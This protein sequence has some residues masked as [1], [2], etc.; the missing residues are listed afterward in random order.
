MMKKFIKSLSLILCA[1]MCAACVFGCAPKTEPTPEPEPDGKQE[2]TETVMAKNG[3]TD[4]KIVVPATASEYIDFAAEELKLRFKEATKAELP[5]VKDSTVS[6]SES[7]KLISIGNTTV[8]TASGVTADFATYG[9]SG[10]KLVSKGD[11][12]ILTGA[13]DEGSLYAVY[14]LLTVLFDYEFY[15]IDAYKLN[16]LDT[17]Y[18]PVLDKS[19]IPDM[20]YRLYGDFL[21][22]RESGNDPH[23]A[24]RL[25]NEPYGQGV[26]V[27][28]HSFY[29]I[30]PKETYQA[31]HPDWFSDNVGGAGLGQLCLTAH[32]NPESR[33]KM[34]EE[35]AKSVES[36]IVA[37]PDSTNVTITQADENIWCNCDGCRSA[38]TKY[39][40]GTEYNGMF[41][42]VPFLND[43]AEVV[44]AWMEENF[45]GRHMTYTTLAYHQTINAPA[46]KNENGDYVPY[47][48]S[49]KLKDN[50]IISYAS[51][52]ANRNIPFRDNPTENDS[53]RA[54][55]AVCKGLQIYEYPQD[56]SHVCLPY[57]GLHVFA[58]NI[59]FAKELGLSNYFF[60]G[61]WG[62]QSSG[63]TPLKAYVT[64]KLMWDSS[65]DPMELAY[66]Y[67]DNCYG[68]AAPYIREYYDALRLRL[69]YM[70][71]TTNYGSMCL[72]NTLSIS[73]W[74]R[75]VIRSF[76]PYF[77]K[78]YAAIDNLQY[79][80]KE[81]YDIVFRKIMIEEM[82][83]RYVNCSLYRNSFSTE[84]KNRMI[85]EFE[86]YAG[87]YG[88]SR[89]SESKPMSDVISDWRR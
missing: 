53:I 84:E 72:G 26:A 31:E 22:D 83:L 44:D 41:T 10:A 5:I 28:G 13:T 37:K 30:M 36:F 51:I 63:F 68:D 65:L 34:V 15:D 20:Q 81:Q 11:C 56:A 86:Y 19:D 45:P 27:S 57:D 85:D 61:N 54:W 32:G 55:A 58:N 3:G 80:N 1:V 66:D 14:D 70:R 33:K 62:T 12:I 40:S 29:K 76:E 43:V 18:T 77:E 7:A 42:L 39:V 67:I 60:Q 64:S 50:I 89:Y 75:S 87:L 47:D 24:W 59:R 52:Y 88:F 25:R 17:V 78:A 46:Y 8:K 9:A 16:K 71:K 79:V 48:E 73:N 4:Y 82:F 69:S 23:H 2:F 38:I 35:F 21:H 49:L 6:Y 74:P